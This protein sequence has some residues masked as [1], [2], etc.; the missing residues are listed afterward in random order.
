MRCGSASAW[1]T[2]IHVYERGYAE[3]LYG[4]GKDK[5]SSASRAGDAA[6]FFFFTVLV[7]LVLAAALV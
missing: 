7:C 6:E 3:V 2:S 1:K 4:S 5:A